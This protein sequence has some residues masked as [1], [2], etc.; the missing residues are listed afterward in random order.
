[1]DLGSSFVGSADTRPRF[2]WCFPFKPRAG[3]GSGAIRRCDNQRLDDG[4]SADRH[5]FRDLPQPVTYRNKSLDTKQIGRELSV[6]YVLEGDVRRSGDRVRVDAQLIDAE[7]DALVWAQQFDGDVGDLFAL[8][9][10]ITGRIAIALG[11]EL[12]DREAARPT[13]YPDAFDYILRGAAVMSAQKTRMT[14]AGRSA[15]SIAR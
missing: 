8:E 4:A 13:R 7:T 6:R 10:D 14:Y 9:D 3:Y 1:V 12:I 2:L 5:S 15:C 11:I